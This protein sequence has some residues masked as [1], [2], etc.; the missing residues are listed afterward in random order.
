[1]VS[2]RE[3]G[4][5]G[6]EDFEARTAGRHGSGGVGAKH[7]V[8]IQLGFSPVSGLCVLMECVRECACALSL[9][10]LSAKQWLSRCGF[11]PEGNV[12]QPESEGSL[13]AAFALTAPPELP[14]LSKSA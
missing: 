9:R 8:Q 4:E 11:N 10:V 5:R 13:G 14:W 2:P 3:R 1:M 6:A 12:D 7:S